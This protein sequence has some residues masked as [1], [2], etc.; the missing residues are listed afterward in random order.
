MVGTNFADFTPPQKAIF[1][2]ADLGVSSPQLDIAERG[3]SFRLNGPLD[4][5]MNQEKGITAKELIHTLEEKELAK[6]IFDYGEERYSRRI[7]RRIQKDLFECGPYE[8]TNPLAYAI[9]G[10]YQP[11]QRYGRCLL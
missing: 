8:S 4:M 6:V 10:C 2:L 3:F 9:A 11:K 5:R 7:D 1:V